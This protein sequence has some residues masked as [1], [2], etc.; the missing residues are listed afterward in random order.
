MQKTSP[1]MQR[2]FL[3]QNKKREINTIILAD[4]HALLPLKPCYSGTP[5]SWV[6]LSS[7]SFSHS[8]LLVNIPIIHTSNSNLSN[9]RLYSQEPLTIQT[10]QTP[11]AFCTSVC[12][13]LNSFTFICCYANHVKCM[14]LVELPV[15]NHHSR[16]KDKEVYIYI[17]NT[18]VIVTWSL[19]NCRSATRTSKLALALSKF[20]CRRAVAYTIKFSGILHLH[21]NLMKI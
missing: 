21:P 13:K 8:A 9:C 1:G 20:F 2:K 15:I 11:E 10:S 19:R 4:K 12:C 18:C 5:V 7:N 6:F 3:H 16:K 17:S 14:A